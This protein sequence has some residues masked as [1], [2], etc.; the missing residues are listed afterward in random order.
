MYWTLPGRPASAKPTQSEDLQQKSSTP[1][2]PID[3]GLDLTLSP[4]KS[5]K[6]TMTSEELFAAIHRSKKRLNLKTDQQPR[7]PESSASTSAK[8][9]LQNFK[10]LLL[11]RGGKDPGKVSAVEQLRL[12]KDV[13]IVKDEPVR[14]QT[15]PKMVKRNQ[16]RFASPRSDVL[17]S[18]I[19]E[20]C[21]EVERPEDALRYRRELESSPLMRRGRGD[22]E[23]SKPPRAIVLQDQRR[24]MNSPQLRAQSPEVVKSFSRGDFELSKPPRAIVL[25]EQRRMMESP[26][27]RAQTPEVRNIQRRSSEPNSRIPVDFEGSKLQTPSNVRD[28]PLSGWQESRES[29][30]RSVESKLVRNNDNVSTQRSLPD[31]PHY[32]DSL[33]RSSPRR[34]TSNT[35]AKITAPLPTTPNR[36]T[37]KEIRLIP[38]HS[39]SNSK[40]VKPSVE[41]PI[42][43]SLQDARK[44][45]FSERSPPTT[46]VPYEFS[47]RFSPFPLEA[48]KIVS[49]SNGLTNQKDSRPNLANGSA[50]FSSS[51]SALSPS[52]N[53]KT[54]RSPNVSLETAL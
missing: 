48:G 13:K 25:Q 6:T 37:E 8:T 28:S 19:L 4:I 44:D 2:K 33:G 42:R 22:F 26:L 12:S 5:P 14:S 45:F 11:Q 21:T 16:W 17:S 30:Q 7:K 20:D 34:L 10:M 36:S 43:K 51:P 38:N 52:C 54:A 18:T 23:L 41:K 50:T 35:Y 32:T 27:L 24:M 39:S 47:R 29:P 9:S 40:D 3:R 53:E 31:P 1:T 49:V 15:P 46:A